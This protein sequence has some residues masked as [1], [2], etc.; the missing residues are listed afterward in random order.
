M[1]R[2][3]DYDGLEMDELHRDFVKLEL[4][5][6]HQHYLPN[7]GLV[8]KNVLDL[9]AGCGE[10]VQFFL[11][12]GAA[13]VLPVEADPACIEMLWRNFKTNEKVQLFTG[14]PFRIDF[15][16]MDIEGAE[17]N[18][19]V[20][21]HFLPYLQNLGLVGRVPYPV[22]LVRLGDRKLLSKSLGWLHLRRI[23]AAHLIRMMIKAV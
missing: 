3:E 8:G 6:W 12:H 19:I 9:G 5:M 22:Y 7:G 17:K 10:T 23:A 13:K 11:N 18:M 15:I 1:C 2:I 21:T 16:K 14:R 4:E 20:E